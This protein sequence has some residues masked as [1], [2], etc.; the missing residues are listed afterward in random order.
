MVN[1]EAMTDK[2][3]AVLIFIA[4]LGALIP[5]LNFILGNFTADAPGAPLG[6]LFSINGIIVLFLMALSLVGIFRAFRGK[7]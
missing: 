6:G 4:V 2:V 3:L 5:E 7:K 1:A